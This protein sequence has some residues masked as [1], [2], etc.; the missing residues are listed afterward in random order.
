MRRENSW[1]KATKGDNE[2][3]KNIAR[4]NDSYESTFEVLTDEIKRYQN[5]RLT[6][7]GGIAMSW[8]NCDFA[9]GL[10]TQ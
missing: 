1:D 6:Y 9:L 2:N 4:V 8:M 10:K 3:S 5:I 7:A